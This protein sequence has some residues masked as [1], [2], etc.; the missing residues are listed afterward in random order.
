MKIIPGKEL[1]KQI[2]AS[3]ALFL[4]TIGFIYIAVTTGWFVIGMIGIA[5]IPG[6]LCRLIAT[7]R[8]FLFCEEGITVCLLWYKRMYRWDELKIKRFVHYKGVPTRISRTPVCLAAEFC[9]KDIHI[10][11]QWD[12]CIYSSWRRPL[13]MIFVYF[14]PPTYQ[15]NKPSS[16]TMTSFP[17]L[18]EADEETFR[19]KLLEWG[20]E[21]EETERGI[22]TKK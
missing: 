1:H 18:Y 21:M 9:A 10:P 17:V 6:C 14:T 20:V 11:Q 22:H 19:A 16:I 15:N 5:F 12:A 7:G 3:I 4:S 8:T 13:S 2:I